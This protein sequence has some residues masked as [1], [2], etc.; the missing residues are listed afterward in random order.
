M[1]MGNKE[2]LKS[3]KPVA[4]IGGLLILFFIYNSIYSFYHLKYYEKIS[5]A[6]AI[7]VNRSGSA[8]YID[9]VYYISGKKY[10]DSQYLRNE[11]GKCKIGK[12]FK[13]KYSYKNPKINNLLI[14][15]EVNDLTK[16][17][18]AEFDSMSD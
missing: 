15:Q 16:I 10:E 2:I 7:R 3:K 4:I 17:H 1:K 11:C 18:E 5:V 12:Y 9:Y 6:K 13:I 14:N 8:E